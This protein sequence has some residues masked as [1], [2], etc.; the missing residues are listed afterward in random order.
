[1]ADDPDP[2]IVLGVRLA[3]GLCRSVGQLSEWGARHAETLASLQQTHPATY[4]AARAEY[5]ARLVELRGRENG[6]SRQT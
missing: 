4:L 3:A 1:M 6:C 2:R 5:G